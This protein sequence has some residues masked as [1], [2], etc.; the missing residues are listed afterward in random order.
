VNLKTIALM[1]CALALVGGAT[2]IAQT[3]KKSSKS[4]GK[5]SRGYRPTE[6]SLVGIKLYDTGVRVVNVYGSPDMIEAVNIG[7]SNAGGGGGGN[8]EGGGGGGGLRTPSGQP[9]AA[10]G[11][12]QNYP[13]SRPD[14]EFA[15]GDSELM[16]QGG[17]QRPGGGETGLGGEGDGGARPGPG[18]PGGGSPGPDG[19]GGGGV[20]GGS[21]EQ[22][23]LTRWIYKRNNSKYGFVMDKFNRVI[24]IEA[25]GLKNTR[26]TTSRGITFGSSFAQIIKAYGAPD[27]YE[28]GGNNVTVRYLTAKKVA[29]RLNR[30]QKDKPYVVTGIV[31]AAGK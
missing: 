6:V 17:K 12:A 16:R 21:S 30:V 1:T 10:P 7:S 24:Q 4:S 29:F 18:G 28:V 20:G 27:G 11:A 9:A 3:K 15:F 13:L 14:G 2:G 5:S 25:I 31:V 26:A 22:T 23:E 8:G 19:R